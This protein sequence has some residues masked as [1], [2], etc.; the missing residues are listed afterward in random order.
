MQLEIPTGITYINLSPNYYYKRKIVQQPS[1]YCT[2]QG[3][4]HCSIMELEQIIHTDTHLSQNNKS[5]KPF[6]KLRA[7]LFQNQTHRASDQ[8][9][10]HH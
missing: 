1:N 10:F 2:Y 6:T 8:D 5:R 9:F 3:I 4:T 7:K